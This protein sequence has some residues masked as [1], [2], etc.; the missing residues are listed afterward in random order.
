[1]FTSL[2]PNITAATFSDDRLSLQNS[3]DCIYFFVFLLMQSSTVAKPIKAVK[4]TQ[5]RRAKQKVQD[6][7]DDDDDV[8]SKPVSAPAAA[9]KSES[10]SSS[11]SSGS[12][13]DE[14]EDFTISSSKKSA[15]VRRQSRRQSMTSRGKY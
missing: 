13:S 4:A 7:D 3:V 5:R 2:V 11:S 12:S 10:E 14:D 9:Q 8:D 6:D 1:M 15:P